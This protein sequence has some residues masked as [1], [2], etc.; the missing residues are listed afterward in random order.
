M[1]HTSF[2]TFLSL[3]I[4]KYNLFSTIISTSFPDTE[5]TPY[6]NKLDHLV[7]LIMSALVN[8]ASSSVKD[9]FGIAK[10]IFG[11]DHKQINTDKFLFC[12][13]WLKARERNNL[14]VDKNLY[15]IR[16]IC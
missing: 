6:F 8:V 13:T 5:T 1:G 4:N 2:L 14:L 3:F 11:K 10:L 12:Q 16:Q 7:G 15:C 9:I